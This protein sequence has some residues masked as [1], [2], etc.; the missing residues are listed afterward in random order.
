MR[1]WSFIKKGTRVKLK[2]FYVLEM[3]DEERQN[4]LKLLDHADQMADELL[5]NEKTKEERVQLSEEWDNFAD[6]VRD[7]FLKK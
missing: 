1:Q 6:S 7:T 5:R 4:F 3:T 2:E